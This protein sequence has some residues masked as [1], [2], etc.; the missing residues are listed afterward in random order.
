MDVNGYVRSLTNT[1]ESHKLV[2]CP[3]IVPLIFQ[4][5]SVNS[6]DTFLSADLC[7]V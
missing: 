4:T 5:F 1:Q 2:F 3:L 7:M 6:Q